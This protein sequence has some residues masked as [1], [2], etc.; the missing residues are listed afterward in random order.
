MNIFNDDYI[1]RKIEVNIAYG[2]KA[3]YISVIRYKSAYVDS[4][5]LLEQIVTPDNIA[6]LLCISKD[7]LLNIMKNNFHG[8]LHYSQ[9]YPRFTFKNLEDT[10]QAKEWIES[11][12]LIDKL[13]DN[14][15]VGQI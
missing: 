11:I 9:V 5:Y 12:F 2:G 3:S 10:V 7:E 14:K 13:G 15:Y 6:K 4:R 1:T 8:Y